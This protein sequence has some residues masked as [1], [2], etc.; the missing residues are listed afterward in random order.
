MCPFLVWLLSYNL[1]FVAIL[2]SVHILRQQGFANFCSN[3]N[4]GF[5]GV[6]NITDQTIPSLGLPHHSNIRVAPTPHCVCGMNELTVTGNYSRTGNQNFIILMLPV[7]CYLY[8]NRHKFF[9]IVP[10]VI[11]VIVTRK[12]HDDICTKI[13]DYG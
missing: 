2:G 5:K 6:L 7:I 11:Y 13:S 12:F 9:T 4:I 1:V 8:R 3:K 10:S